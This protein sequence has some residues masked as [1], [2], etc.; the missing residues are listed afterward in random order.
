VTLQ[1]QPLLNRIKQI[2]ENYSKTPTQVLSLFLMHSVFLFPCPKTLRKIQKSN[3]VIHIKLSKCTPSILH[4]IICLLVLLC[5]AV[6][7]ALNWLVAQGNVIPIPGAKNA[8]QAKEFAGAIGWSLTDNE[9]S[10][11]RSLASEI[12]PVVGF[13]VEYL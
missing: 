2:G 7:I 8:E 12:K 13:P 4:Q 5:C 10:E 1:L 6:Q 9:V 3:C 11:L